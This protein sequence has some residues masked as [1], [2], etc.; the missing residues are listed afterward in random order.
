MG[1]E[2]MLRISEFIRL[3]LEGRS[4]RPREGITLIWNL[5][6]A[7]NLSC[8][9]CYASAGKRA[10]NELSTGEVLDLIPDLKQ[11]GVS[12]VVLSGGE[13]LMREDIFEIGQ[14]LRKKSIRTFLSTNGLLITKDNV[15][16]IARTFDYVGI[17]IDG[18]PSVHDAFRGK[19][20][21]FEGSLRSLELCLSW[22]LKTG[23]R[24]TLTE[25]TA[26]SLPFVFD[27]ASDLGVD[28]LYISHLVFSG[29]GKSLS[30]PEKLALRKLVEF[31]VDYALDSA[32]EERKPDIITGNSEPD[33]VVLLERFG[34]RYPE[35]TPYLREILKSWGGN[36]AG[37]SLFC[38]TPEGDVKPD[39][40]FFH[41]LGNLR[42]KSFGEIISGNGILS[43][44][45]ERP[46]R[47]KGRCER[48]R[49]LSFC[50]GGSRA[51]AYAVYG[52]YFMEDPACYLS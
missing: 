3:A 38:I 42:E 21:A 30:A 29:R 32:R 14:A 46:R 28:R 26:G 50:N 1:E 49:Y 11:S 8:S 24:F 17:S 2:H 52:D 33:A 9:H 15:S 10:K 36:R 37:E 51:R 48:C 18:T 20:F 31:I 19:S 23:I 39:P 12:S 45:R 34:K 13:P 4:Y 22:R 44:L 5:T 16:D 7:C 25:F 6:K 40:F 47:I 43:R 35:K 27:L 41:T